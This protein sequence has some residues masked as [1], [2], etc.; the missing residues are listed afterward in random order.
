M[1]ITVH[2]GTHQIGGMATE[3]ATNQT[4]IVIDMGDELGPDPQPLNIPGVTDDSQACDA[5]LFTHYHGDHMGQIDR[6]RTDIPL[7]MGALSK[8]I[9]LKSSQNQCLNKGQWL[10]NA[11]V[12]EMGCPFIIKDMKITPFLVDHSAID[13]YMFLIEA[14]GK[15]ILHTGDFRM[16]GFR[17]KALPKLL[18]WKLRNIDVLIMEGTT[19]SRQEQGPIITEYDLQQMVKE[20]LCQYKYVF[21]LCAATN[22]ERVFGFCHAVPKKKYFICDSYQKD[23]LELASEQ[24]KKYSSLYRIPKITVY[25]DNLLERFKEKGFLMMVRANQTFK[26]IIQ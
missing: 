21:V 15:R 14:E 26:R 7:Y 3:I 20:Y 10:E 1:K 18:D 13:S 17:G 6:I 12:F 2:R 19:L 8:A 11:H 25:G 23:L 16:H 24:L 22:L 5:V 4:R 9:W